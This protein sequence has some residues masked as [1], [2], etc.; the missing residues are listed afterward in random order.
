MNDNNIHYLKLMLINILHDLH[1][2]AEKNSVEMKTE[3]KR[4]SDPYDQATA[5]LG[6][7]VD[8]M[9]RS[10]EWE[11]IREIEEALTRIDR[12]KFGICRTCE[13]PISAKRL[14]VK[15]TSLLC[16][17]CKENEERRRRGR[18]IPDTHPAMSSHAF[19]A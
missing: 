8:L 1:L 19:M 7:S 4:F 11:M 9:I 2:S 13:R 17:E 6:R 5:E 15:P 16:I 14:L 10:R 12:G 3:E 18:G